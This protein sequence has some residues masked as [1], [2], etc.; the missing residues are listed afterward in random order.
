MGTRTV[1]RIVVRDEL[2]E[3]YAA[4]FEGLEMKIKNGQTILTG[5]IVD[6]PHL[7]GILDRIGALGLKLVSVE[8]MSEG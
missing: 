6:Q 1:Y 8:D 3:R 4:A 2:S 7:H 5:E